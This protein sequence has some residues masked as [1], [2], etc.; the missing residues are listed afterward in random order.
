MVV[1]RA[2]PERDGVLDCLK[3]LAIILVVAGH[4]LQG[5]TPDFDNLFAFR[6]IYAFHMPMFMFVAGMVIA[7]SLR[8]VFPVQQLAATIRSVAHG[9]PKRVGRLLIPFFVWG[10]VA[11]FYPGMPEETLTSWL[12][13]LVRTPDYGLWFLLALFDCYLVMAPCL[14]LAAALMAR[15][16][17]DRHSRDRFLIMSLSLLL[18]EIALALGDFG[19]AL[20]KL[21]YPFVVLGFLYQIFLPRGLAL[22]AR[23][24]AAAAFLLLMPFWYRLEGFSFLAGLPHGSLL[25]LLLRTAMALGG[26]SITIEVARLLERY[27]HA[28]VRQTI[29]HCGRRSLEIYALHFYFL[30]YRPAIVAPIGLSLLVSLFL[31]NVPILGAMLFGEVPSWQRQILRRLSGSPF[32]GN[33]NPAGVAHQTAQLQAEPPAI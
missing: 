13:K 30:G 10:I 4:T 21:F 26:T 8:K 7:V 11:L 29:G 27:V 17:R 18:G 20:A 12:D 2:V 23:I 1:A 22:W 24:G 5:S 14:I 6:A 28:L 19:F 15:G 32:P 33:S 16:G 3:G 31:R 9:I 25:N